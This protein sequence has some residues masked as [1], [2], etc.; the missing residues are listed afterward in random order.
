MIK[1]NDYVYIRSRVLLKVFCIERTV[2]LVLHI[3]INHQIDSK[4]LIADIRRTEIEHYA[5]EG[6]SI[7]L[8][9]I[10]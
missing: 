5:R 8:F 9:L 2:F 3:A 7:T 10:F 1:K 4:I 6:T